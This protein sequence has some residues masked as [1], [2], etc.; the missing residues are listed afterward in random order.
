V[1]FV[2]P[3]RTTASKMLL[4]VVI[5]WKSIFIPSAAFRTLVRPMLL[6]PAVGP[7]SAPVPTKSMA[8]EA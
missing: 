5:A 1:I 8:V 7:A 3:K 4:L 6:V 2:A